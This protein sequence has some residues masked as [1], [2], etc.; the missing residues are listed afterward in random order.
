NPADPN[1]DNDLMSDVEEIIANTDPL[2]PD[3]FLWVQIDPSS[4]LFFQNLT[5][6]AST[7]RT[8]RI[9]GAT[10]LYTGPWMIL[11]SNLTALTNGLLI[12]PDSNDQGRLYYRVGVESP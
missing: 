12:V 11:Q 9:E 2:D 1:D 5:F 7:G 6:P 10:N 4:N 3:S 8:Y